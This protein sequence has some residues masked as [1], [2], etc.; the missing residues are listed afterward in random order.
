MKTERITFRLNDELKN[1]LLEIANNKNISLSQY[2]NELLQHC[3]E[4]KEN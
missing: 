3:I 4:N 1:E 2:I